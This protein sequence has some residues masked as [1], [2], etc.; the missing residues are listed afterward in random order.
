VANKTPLRS[1]LDFLESKELKRTIEDSIQYM[2]IIFEDAKDSEN[3]LY[4]EETYRVIVLYVISIIEAI[5]LYVLKKR[6]DK[7]MHS[8]Y[9]YVTAINPS[10]R[11][12]ELPNSTVVV[13][14]QKEEEKDERTIK[15]SDIV[16]FMKKGGLMDKKFAE[17]ILDVNSI[18]N[19]FHFTKPRNKI[20]CEIKTVEKA[21][22]LLV[23]T[24]KRAPRAISYRKNQ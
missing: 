13:A 23:D 6:D 22:E 16:D 1:T 3:P 18:R 7:I 12:S 2:Y 11:H 14:V 17:R 24:I 9:K 15:L 8:Q 19:T 20:T 5:L 21:L 4:K 10:F